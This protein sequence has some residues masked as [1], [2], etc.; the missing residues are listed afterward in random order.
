MKRNEAQNYLRSQLDKFGLRGWKIRVSYDEKANYLG[1]CDY[2][3]NTIIL[4]SYHVELHPESEVKDTCLHEIAHALVGPNE[5]HNLIWQAKATEIGAKPLALCTHL[6]LPPEVIDAIRSGHEVET[7][8]KVHTVTSHEFKIKVIKERCP[9]CGKEA[10]EKFRFKTIDHEGNEVEIITLKC[11]HVI[12]KVIPRATPFESLISNHWRNE[13]KN[14]KH[15]FNPSNLDAPNQCIHCGE[16]KLLPFQLIGAKST[17]V[18]CATGRGFGIFDDMGLGKTVQSLAYL[19]FHKERFPVLYV[20]KTKIKFNWLKQIVRWLGQD[21]FAQMIN[22]SR[23]FVFPNLKGYIISHDLLRNFPL[24][25]I[26]G[27]GIKTIII[28]EVQQF[29][30]PDSSRTGALRTLIKAL[31]EDTKII[32]LSGTPWKNRGSEYFVAL[33]MIAPSKFNSYARFVR[34]WVDIIVDEN[35]KSKQGGIRNIPRFKEYVK[36][37]LIRRE[38]EEVMQVFPETNRVPLHVQLDDF[39]QKQYD[40]EVSNFVSW[41]NEELAKNDYEREVNS[42]AIIAKLQK[43]RHIVGLAKIPVTV[44]FVEEFIEETDKKLVIFVHHKDVHSLLVDD[45]KKIVGDKFPVYSWYVER[46][47][48]VVFSET[49]QFNKDKRAI[50]IASTLAFGEGID[51]QSCADCIMHERQWNPQNEDQAAPGRFRRIGQK[52]QQVNITFPIAEGTV[53]EHLDY[54]VS[55]KRRYFHE[56]MNKGEVPTWDENE[57]VQKIAQMIIEGARSK[58]KDNVNRPSITEMARF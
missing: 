56:V 40:N 41:Y 13:I 2:D 53:D 6:S 12:K 10:I 21:Y 15:E 30:N 45:I 31:G 55:R 51:L 14:C 23:D 27:L 4:N 17:E 28:D 43:M 33:N 39:E 5:S 20:V 11:F 38:Y 16:F 42:L 26:T 18:A 8:E 9:D 44:A 48:D 3:N 52:A 58:K 19:H 25:K 49:E 36:D 50:A 46:G 37:I 57:I 22:T 35:G 7:V 47:E 54:L 32:N 1:L 24:D 34:E 29:K